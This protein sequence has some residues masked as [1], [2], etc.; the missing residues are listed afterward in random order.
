MSRRRSKRLALGR[1]FGRTLALGLAAAALAAAMPA[2]ALAQTSTLDDYRDRVGRAR[3][4]T[5]RSLP[6]ARREVTAQALGGELTSL[7]PGVEEVRVG[8]ATVVVDN[9]TLSSLVVAL[10]AAKT[11]LDR[12]RATE[13]IHRYLTTLDHVLAVPEAAPVV[14]DPAALRQLLARREPSADSGLTRALSRLVDRVLAWLSERLSNL[15]ARDASPVTRV[16]IAVVVGML[17]AALGWAALALW[18]AAR[19]STAAK[20][21]AALG[22]GAA[23]VVPEADGLPSDVLAHADGLAALGDRRAAVRALFGG[24]ARLLAERGLVPPV[25]ARTNA[26]LLA[27]AAASLPATGPVFGELTER[28]ERAWYGHADPGA[29]GYDGARSSYVGLARLVKHAGEGRDEAA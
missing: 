13:D 20:E 9:G 14:Q 25:R 19:R 11:D 2:A 16:V 15:S 4:L 21:Q 12:E 26:E 27:S 3:E 6:N 7:V 23:S 1:A 8:S 10:E 17:G 28:F 24:A 5:E 29:D 22:D 18:R